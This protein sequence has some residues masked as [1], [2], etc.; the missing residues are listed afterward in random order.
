MSSYMATRDGNRGLCTNSCRWKYAVVEETRPGQYFP[1]EEDETGTY[2]FNS[3]DLCAIELVDQI[4]KAGVTSFKI[5]GRTKGLLYGAT[6]AK[7]YRAAIQS[8]ESGNF[9]FQPQW[10]EELNS[11]AYRGYTQGFFNGKLQEPKDASSSALP[12]GQKELIAIVKSVRKPFEYKLAVRNQIKVGA[13][14]EAV[15]PGEPTRK[16]LI[17]N[18]IDEA[19]GESRDVANPNQTIIATMD[20]NLEPDDLLRQAIRDGGLPDCRR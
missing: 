3:Q 1:V 12:L 2:M 11:V 18:I 6:T 13:M 8:I 15:R 14:V 17:A 10:R 7:T 9:E 20:L 4:V 5:E 19:T 16:S